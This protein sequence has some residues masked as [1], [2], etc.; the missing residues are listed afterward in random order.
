MFLL[1]IF[2]ATIHWVIDVCRTLQ[3]PL[4]P[5]FSLRDLSQRGHAHFAAS[6]GKFRDLH[7][8]PGNSECRL[9]LIANAVEPDIQGLL[10]IHDAACAGSIA[11][12]ERLSQSGPGSAS[13]TQDQ[14]R[15]RALDLALQSAR[16]ARAKWLLLE[17]KV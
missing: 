1:M 7:D 9:I 2:V 6:S 13:V 16:F 17:T 8:A 12:V 3:E 15:Y 4:G 14:N 11:D 10:A 5:F